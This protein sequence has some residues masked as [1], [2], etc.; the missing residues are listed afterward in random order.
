MHI[1][2]QY[3]STEKVDVNRIKSVLAMAWN[4]QRRSRCATAVLEAY[5]IKMIQDGH[6]A[7][8]RGQGSDRPDVYIW[9][10]PREKQFLL[11]SRTYYSALGSADPSVTKRVF[12]KKLED[13]G[14]L[15]TCQRNKQIRRTFEIKLS[16]NTLKTAVLK[17]SME[18]FSKKFFESIKVQRQLRL[19]ETDASSFRSGSTIV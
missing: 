13:E 18:K 19:M 11:P 2:F 12:E 8:V 10:D 14:T 5:V 16:P 7:R 1:F 17:V 9:Y 6:C 4:Q 3:C 15:C